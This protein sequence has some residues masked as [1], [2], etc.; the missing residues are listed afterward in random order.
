MLDMPPLFSLTLFTHG[1]TTPH[2]SATGSC[3][4]RLRSKASQW[5]K[6]SG[7]EFLYYYFGTTITPCLQACRSMSPWRL[8]Q[9]LPR[10]YFPRRKCQIL[11]VIK[12][13]VNKHPAIKWKCFWNCDTLRIH[14]ERMFSRPSICISTWAFTGVIGSSG[15]QC[16]EI[17][18]ARILSATRS[19][20]SLLLYHLGCFYVSSCISL[21]LHF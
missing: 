4:G 7:T 2:P 1:K 11:R 16:W 19:A 6:N 3:H 15:T 20:R 5:R 10:N 14:T 21:A 9:T 8:Q 13:C 12:R 17:K 18:Y